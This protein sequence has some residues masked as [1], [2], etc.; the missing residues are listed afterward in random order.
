MT[1]LNQGLHSKPLEYVFNK[2]LHKTY[3]IR[4]QQSEIMTDQPFAN[5]ILEDLTIMLVEMGP[6][7]GQLNQNP[8]YFKN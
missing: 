6:M 3:V 2:T 5:C 7:S 4:T 8:L 1:A